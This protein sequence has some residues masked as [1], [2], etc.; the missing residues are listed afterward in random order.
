M[1]ILIKNFTFGIFVCI[2]S[3]CEPDVYICTEDQNLIEN[4]EDAYVLYSID[5]GKSIDPSNYEEPF[6][7][8]VKLVE[9]SRRI[10]I[11]VAHLASGNKESIFCSVT[12]ADRTKTRINEVIEQKRQVEN[13]RDRLDSLFQDS[14][15]MG[16]IEI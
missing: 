15:R 4:L 11:P 3:G 8:S 9:L 2:L 7:E 12:C 14:L 1:K 6:M 10:N 5:D 16:L 13:E